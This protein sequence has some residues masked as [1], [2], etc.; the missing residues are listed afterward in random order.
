[1]TY[2]IKESHNRESGGKGSGIIIVRLGDLGNP[3]S[4][5]LLMVLSSSDQKIITCCNIPRGN[6]FH[7]NFIIIWGSQAKINSRFYS[8]WK[9][10]SVFFVILCHG[11]ICYYINRFMIW[12]YNLQSSLH[13][14][15]YLYLYNLNSSSALVFTMPG[16]YYSCSSIII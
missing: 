3:Y 6:I 5:N 9:D 15:V 11:E 7:I 12:N 14:L 10:L 1:M 8:P 2:Q 13:I 16:R 4:C